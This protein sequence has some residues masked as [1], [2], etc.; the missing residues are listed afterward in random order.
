MDARF[1]ATAFATVADTESHPRGQREAGRMRQYCRTGN[2]KLRFPLPLFYVGHVA[3]LALIM[4]PNMINSIRGYVPIWCNLQSAFDGKKYGIWIKDET[5]MVL[6][7]ASEKFWKQPHVT[8]VLETQPAAGLKADFL[9]LPAL[10]PLQ[11]GGAGYVMQVLSCP[12]VKCS[13]SYPHRCHLSLIFAVNLRKMVHRYSEKW[14]I[15]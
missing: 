13:F 14:F 11:T 4:W 6:F 9:D 10:W 12:E 1:L 8:H 5:H 2:G 3:P 15:E 7:W